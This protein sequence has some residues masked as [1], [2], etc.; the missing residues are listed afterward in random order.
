MYIHLIGSVFPEKPNTCTFPFADRAEQSLGDEHHITCQRISL[1][2]PQLL[3]IH[4]IERIFIF[5]GLP[6]QEFKTTLKG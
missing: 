3:K 2:V 5:K 1:P 4:H 6:F